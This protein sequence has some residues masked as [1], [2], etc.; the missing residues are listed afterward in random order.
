MVKAGEAGK[1]EG[2]YLPVVWTLLSMKK[3]AQ[4]QL[5]GSVKI[6][7][8]LERQSKSPS[9]MDQRQ[10]ESSSLQGKNLKNTSQ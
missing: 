5:L 4:F 8:V 10:D 2:L 9:Q 1:K 7:R 6:K 3:E